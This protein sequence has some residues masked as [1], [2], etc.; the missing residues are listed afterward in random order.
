MS[1][2]GDGECFLMDD[3]GTDAGENIHF[4]NGLLLPKAPDFDPGYVTDGNYDKNPQGHFCIDREGRVV[5]YG[6]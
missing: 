3:Y 5:S 4:D 1:L 6:P 2:T